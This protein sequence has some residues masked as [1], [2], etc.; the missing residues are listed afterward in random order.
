VE[1]SHSAILMRSGDYPS[2]VVAKSQRIRVGWSRA[3]CGKP[4]D[5]YGAKAKYCEDALAGFHCSVSL[6]YVVFHAHRT[7]R[8]NARFRCFVKLCKA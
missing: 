2:I 4:Y 7:M 1:L 8:R 5:H 3:N 6:R